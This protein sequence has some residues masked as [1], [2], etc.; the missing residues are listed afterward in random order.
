[1]ARR[2]VCPSAFQVR[3]AFHSTT[4]GSVW[5]P[6]TFSAE[7][8]EF[9]VLSFVSLFVSFCL[10]RNRRRSVPVRVHLS[11][12]YL[13][14]TVVLRECSLSSSRRARLS[15]RHLVDWFGRSRRKE[16]ESDGRGRGQTGRRRPSRGRRQGQLGSAEADRTRDSR[17]HRQTTR[18]Q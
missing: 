10:C 5:L 6:T 18:S 12:R 9:V 17:R 13:Q 8:T 1:M 16:R 15:G 11:F 2:C 14:R 4:Y 7:R 3:S